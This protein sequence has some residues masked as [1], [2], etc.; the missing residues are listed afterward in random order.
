M[1]GRRWRELPEKIEIAPQQS[2][3]LLNLPIPVSNA[4]ASNGQSTLIRASSSD[5]VY[6]ANLALKAPLAA[7]GKERAPT[8]E[9]WLN[10]LQSSGLAA[11]RDRTPTPL[12]PEVI[13][14]ITFSRVAGV[15]KGT[16]WQVKIVDRDNDSILSIASTG[17]AFSYPLNTPQ[18]VR[19][20]M[21]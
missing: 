19:H 18:I 7:D 20:R 2:Y 11:P 17:S 21:F 16:Q 15:S 5:R 14:P 1:L 9:E 10:L 3:L 6:V 13:L 4:P 8:L 12:E